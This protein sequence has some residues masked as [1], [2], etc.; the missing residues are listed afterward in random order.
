MIIC[1]PQQIRTLGGVRGYPYSDSK[2]DDELFVHDNLCLLER[3]A[4]FR[5][6]LGE[7]RT[8]GLGTRQHVLF[9]LPA[10][11]RTV[12]CRMSAFTSSVTESGQSVFCPQAG[13]RNCNSS[14]ARPECL[15][16][17]CRVSLCHQQGMFINYEECFAVTG[18][19]APQRC[20]RPSTP[21]DFIS[22]IRYDRGCLD[23][24]RSIV[25]RYGSNLI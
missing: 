6:R 15:G 11:A 18:C 4:L 17:R 23:T 16:A 14:I 24:N 12:L 5:C 22:S 9:Q 1:W 20:S 19:L 7:S 13:S 10:S 21:Q 25:K 3:K 2:L 8:S